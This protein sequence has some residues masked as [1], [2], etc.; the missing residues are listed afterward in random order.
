VERE[1]GPA[2]I[3]DV[4]RCEKAFLG[5]Q[6]GTA[7]LRKKAVASQSEPG[8]GNFRV[9]PGLGFDVFLQSFGVSGG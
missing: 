4:I 1:E 2:G 3:A 7:S 9:K 8:A 6:Y 5:P